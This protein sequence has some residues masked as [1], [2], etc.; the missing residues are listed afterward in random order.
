MPLHWKGLPLG[1]NASPPAGWDA[2]AFNDARWRKVRVPGMWEDQFT[3]LEDHNGLFLYRTSFELTE[4]M[5]AR[6]MTLALGAIDD[7]DWTSVNGHPVGSVTAKTNPK[8][9]WMAVR[10]YRVPA[11]VLKPGR[12]I[13][14]IKVNDLR[15]AGGIKGMSSAGA[16][17]ASAGRWRRGLY[18]DEPEEWDD[19]YRFFRW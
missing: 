16:P 17:K 11:A 18:L 7:E 12:N 3:D 10:R 13:L 5:A 15:Q 4:E 2:A 1:K 6:D 9:Y 8:D 14:A 19:P